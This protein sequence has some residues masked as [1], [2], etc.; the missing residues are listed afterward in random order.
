MIEHS[1]YHLGQFA[2]LKNN[3]TLKAEF[4]QTTG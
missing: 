3:L 1:Y 2:R 4:K